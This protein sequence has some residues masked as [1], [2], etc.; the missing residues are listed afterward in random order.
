LSDK[1]NPSNPTS[2]FAQNPV[3]SPLNHSGN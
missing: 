1:D 2:S 3:K